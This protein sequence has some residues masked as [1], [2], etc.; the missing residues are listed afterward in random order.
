MSCHVQG[1][2]QMKIEISIEKKTEEKPLPP[3]IWDGFA[4]WYPMS[5]EEDDEYEHYGY[6]E[7]I[8]E[9]IQALQNLYRIEIGKR[10]KENSLCSRCVYTN[11][12]WHLGTPDCPDYKRDPPDGGYYG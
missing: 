11:T 4:D 7:T 5:V 6:F 10:V 9:A 12:C 1:I 8:N 2:N 3:G